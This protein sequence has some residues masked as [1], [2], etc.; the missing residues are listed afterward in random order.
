MREQKLLINGIF[1]TASINYPVWTVNVNTKQAIG[2][3]SCKTT[4]MRKVNINHP[5]TSTNV[6]LRA[7]CQSIYKA[8]VWHGFNFSG[9]KALNSVRH[10][11]VSSWDKHEV[12]VFS[13]GETRSVLFF[14]WL[15]VGLHG[16]DAVA[17]YGRRCRDDTRTS[18]A[19]TAARAGLPPR[20]R[21]RRLTRGTLF[22]FG[23]QHFCSCKQREH[24]QFSRP[25]E[26][27]Y[28]LWF[29]HIHGHGYGWIRV[30]VHC[31]ETGTD[32]CPQM[33]TAAIFRTGPRLWTG[34]WVRLD[35]C[36]WAIR[37]KP[38]LIS[39]S[40]SCMPMTHEK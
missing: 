36:E 10:V 15:G 18:A 14:L 19:V 6:F 17:R 33:A 29:L 21:E 34:M 22:G 4:L 37:N 3:S 9:L 32:F 7:D 26:T 13:F 20:P 25:I 38:W 28:P 16:V 35:V 1:L 24:N 39:I 40:K 27:S 5:F 8:L 2:L 23:V 11:N 12:P 31:R 30:R